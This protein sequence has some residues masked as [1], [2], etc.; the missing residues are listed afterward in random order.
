MEETAWRAAVP[1][2]SHDCLPVQGKRAS[3]HGVESKCFMQDVSMTQQIL[4]LLL[5]IKQI[6]CQGRF[7]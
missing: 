3:G 5:E 2:R 1:I 4:P 6:D 7:Q